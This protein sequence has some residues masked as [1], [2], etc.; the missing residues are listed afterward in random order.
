MVGDAEIGEDE[1]G[2]QLGGRLL[3]GQHIAA[4]ALVEIAVET[5]LRPRAVSSFMNQ[6][7]IV[8]CGLV[9]SLERRHEDVVE[10]DPVVG[11]V[12]PKGDRD[13]QVDERVALGEAFGLRDCF[14]G[15]SANASVSAIGASEI[16]SCRTIADVCIRPIFNIRYWDVFENPHPSPATSGLYA[17]R[18]RQ[19]PH[20]D[21]GPRER[22]RE[23]IDNRLQG[24]RLGGRDAP[25][26]LGG[27][28]A[29]VRVGPAGAPLG[30]AGPSTT[31]PALTVNAESRQVG[32]RISGLRFQRAWWVAPDT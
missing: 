8:S 25:K 18:E 17:G 30:G 20:S 16:K 3:D 29:P 10:V 19:R 7:A 11:A 22:Q 6:R 14:S 31:D 13:L 1:A 32:K 15:S 24:G 23:R 2:G 5:M 21:A 12:G 28:L 26:A 9:E 27:A 4:E